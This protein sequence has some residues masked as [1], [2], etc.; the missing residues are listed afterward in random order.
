MSVIEQSPTV[1]ATRMR[2]SVVTARLGTAVFALW[3]FVCALAVMKTGA[4][5]L[6]P[7]LEGSVFTDTAVST[8]GFGWLSAMLVMSGSPIAASAL[9]LL[10]GDALT[11]PQA[12]TMLTGSRLGAAFVVL[13]VAVIYAFRGGV[14]GRKA[15][16]SIGIFSL[17]LTA[18]VYVPALAIGLPLL[19]SDAVAHVTPATPVTMV[20]FIERITDPVLNATTSIVPGSMLFL[21]GLAMLLLA[22]KLFDRIVP[23]TSSVG[24]DEHGDWRSRKWIMFGLGSLVAL[25]TMSVAVALTVLVPLVAKGYLRRRQALPYIMGANIMTLGDTLMAALLIGNPDAP[26]VV[27]AELLGVSAITLLLLAFAYQPLTEATVRLTDWMLVSKVRL[28]GFVAALF[29]VPLTLVLAF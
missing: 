2:G 11:T 10:D 26:K 14:N 27:V 23:E 6:A 20:D 8:L 25:I 4:R 21:A 1:T 22:L 24:L 28:G 17:V 7:T 5:E 12:F 29:C 18:I 13:T 3:I 9:T 16:L 15:P 19:T